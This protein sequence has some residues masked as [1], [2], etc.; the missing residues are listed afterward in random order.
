MVSK[1]E[2]FTGNSE[3]ARDGRRHRGT[4]GGKRKTKRKL[5]QFSWRQTGKHI[6]KEPRP[7]RKHGASWGVGGQQTPGQVGRRSEQRYLVWW[8]F[9]R[10]AAWSDCWEGS[11]SQGDLDSGRHATPWERSGTEDVSPGGRIRHLKTKSKFTLIRCFINSLYNTLS[12]CVYIASVFHISFDL[13]CV[14]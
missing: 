10:W 6:P 12:N 7:S 13:H 2:K 3:Q 8:C 11:W 9:C 4:R 1:N 14:N 5:I